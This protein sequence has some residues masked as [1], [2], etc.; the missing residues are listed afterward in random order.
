MLGALSP[1]TTVQ[2]AG[3][4]TTPPACSSAWGWELKVLFS[5]WWPSLPQRWLSLDHLPLG[6][7]QLD[8]TGDTEGYQREA[9]PVGP[10]W[11]HHLHPG[12]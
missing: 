9:V 2:G 8:H 3:V 4:A 12:S 6:E 10:P 7:N 11:Q 5:S 1:D